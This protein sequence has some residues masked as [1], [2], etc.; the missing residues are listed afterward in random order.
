MKIL[1]MIFSNSDLNNEYDKISEKDFLYLIKNC[2]D[3]KI[4][5]FKQ[6]IEDKGIIKDTKKYEIERIIK[7]FSGFIEGEVIVDNKKY[8]DG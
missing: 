1:I 5:N 2:N 8:K 6:R 3:I 4:S 7:H